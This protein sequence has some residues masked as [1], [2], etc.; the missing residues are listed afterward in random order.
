MKFRTTIENLKAKNVNILIVKWLSC[1]KYS[2]LV[3]P[4]NFIQPFT[5]P[6]ARLLGVQ[7]NQSPDFAKERRVMS[8]SCVLFW[9]STHRALPINRS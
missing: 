2:I 9:G 1:N 8:V 6:E 3:C 5:E 7:K 4:A